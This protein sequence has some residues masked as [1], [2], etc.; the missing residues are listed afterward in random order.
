M[1]KKTVREVALDILIQI[2]KDQAYSNLLLNQRVKKDNLDIRDVGLLTEIVYGTVQRRST[3]DFYLTP[4]IKKGKNKLEDWVRLLLMLSVYQMVYLDRVPNHAIINEAVT[5]AKKRSH[6]GVAGMVNG[7]LRN[8]ARTGVPET[9]SISDEIKRLS[10]ETSHPSWLIRRWI[11]LFGFEEARKI[12]EINLTPPS[13]TVRVNLTKGTV[14][15]AIDRLEEEGVK[16]KHGELSPDGL[17]IEE[18][19]IPATYSF[20]KG[21]ITIQDESAMLVARALDPKPGMK[22]LD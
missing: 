17:V 5:I 19:F 7:V 15:E 9:S 18:G 8:I 1:R 3:L 6:Q 13:V 20:Q 11:E 12:A 4:F 22:G 2:E 14:E 21:F 10:I 16:V